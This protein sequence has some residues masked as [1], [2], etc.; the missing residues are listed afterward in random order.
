MI[1][2]TQTIIDNYKIKKT[3]FQ[4]KN[5]LRKNKDLREN[6]GVVLDLKENQALYYIKEESIN[7]F[8]EYFNNK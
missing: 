5:V 3:L 6:I 7:K 8:V 1:R 2:M 4:I